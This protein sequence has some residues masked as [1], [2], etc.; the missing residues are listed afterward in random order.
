MLNLYAADALL[1][2]LITELFEG[3]QMIKPLQ[4]TLQSYRWSG[5]A[6]VGT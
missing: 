4:P 1:L 3:R 6:R 5:S 2:D